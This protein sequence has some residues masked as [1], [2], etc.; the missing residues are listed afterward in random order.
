MTLSIFRRQQA[1]ILSKVS[2]SP[3]TRPRRHSGCFDRCEGLQKARSTE[4][5]GYEFGYGDLPKQVVVFS[6]KCEAE[7]V[8]AWEANDR[9][10]LFPEGAGAR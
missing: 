3:P 6:I 4:P 10:V 2:G 8:K 1:L 9:I 7:S 5:V